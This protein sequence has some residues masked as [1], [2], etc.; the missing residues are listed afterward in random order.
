MKNTIS[1]K[2]IAFCLLLLVT[3]LFQA[4]EDDESFDVV[5][6]PNNIVYIL[7]ATKSFDMVTTPVGFF[8]DSIYADFGVKS[9]NPMKESVTVTATIDNSLV[10]T[11]NEENSTDYMTCTASLA[12]ATATISEGEYASFD[13][14]KV[15]LPE[16]NYPEIEEIGSYLVPV[17]LSGVSTG[18]VSAEYNVVYLEIN[19]EQKLINENVGSGDIQGSLVA[20][21]STWTATSTDSSV[22]DFSSVFDGNNGSGVRFGNE[23]NPTITID[24]QEEK[25][26]SAFYFKNSNSS[27][28]HYFNF[29][30]I[31]VELSSDGNTW[32]DAGTTSPVIE[33]LTDQYVILYGAVPSRYIRITVAWA[34]GNYG[35]YYRSFNEFNVYAE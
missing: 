16:E 9:T 17:K 2:N 33:N 1:I 20:D 26:V 27:W 23:S 25:N 22:G 24:M 10:S 29:S 31:H 18:I 4:C 32:I 13:S 35:S 30:S 34:Y 19:V 8:G 14:I 12:K 15:I 7:P 3:F 21:R 6:N 11:Y 5:G 28:G